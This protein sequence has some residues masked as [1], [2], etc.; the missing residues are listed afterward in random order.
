[1]QDRSTGE[2]F[3]LYAPAREQ[4]IVS[5]ITLAELLRLSQAARA[6]QEQRP[7]A[8]ERLVAVLDESP[9]PIR[10]LSQRWSRADLM[11]LAAVLIALAALLVPLLKDDGAVTPK[12]LVDLVEKVIEQNQSGGDEQSPA[13][14]AQQGADAA[15]PG[16]DAAPVEPEG[17]D[18]QRLPDTPGNQPSVHQPGE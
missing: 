18:G 4:I 13:D 14:E 15:S 10:D 5:A 16:E 11:Q 1:M 3:D 12:E 6:L 9:A 17:A 8:E 2:Q 7:G